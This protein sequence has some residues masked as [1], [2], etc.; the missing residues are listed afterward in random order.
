MVLDISCSE[1]AIRLEGDHPL[2]LLDV[3]EDWELE[4]CA[5][6]QAHHIPLSE[7]SGR[8]GELAPEKPLAI[9]CHHGVRSRHA[10]RFL[11]D[12]GFKEVFNVR[13]G[14]DAWAL[15]IERDMSRYD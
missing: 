11:E 13:G 12:R 5:I 2:D 15:D 10:G 7:L 8:V 6:S 9:I 14:I 1:L 4:I 3:R